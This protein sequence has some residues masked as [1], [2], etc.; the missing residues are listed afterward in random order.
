MHMQITQAIT[1]SL[2]QDIHASKN[3]TARGPAS[4]NLLIR[5][6]CL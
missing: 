3:L 5:S 2:T 6:P 4:M 1:L